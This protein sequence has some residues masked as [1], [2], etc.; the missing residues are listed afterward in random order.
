MGGASK[1]AVQL[2]GH[3]MIAY[4]LR[5]LAQ[6]CEPVAVICKAATELSPLPPG[7]E[8]WDEPDSPRHPA[9]GIA[10]ALERAGGSVLV[11]AADMPFVTADACRTLV[12][13]AAA[14]PDA[15]AIVA[16][17][18]GRLQPVFGVYRPTALGSL[19]AAGDAPLTRLVEALAPVLV[20]FAPAI[21]RSINTR[22]DLTGAEGE[23]GAVAGVEATRHSRDRR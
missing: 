7:V 22:E 11:C 14:A 20:A 13:E 10:H 23:L 12:R 19:R 3:P 9:T 17:A 1:P 6:A 21:V 15:P 5:A 16:E 2:A 4:P 8:R 18:G